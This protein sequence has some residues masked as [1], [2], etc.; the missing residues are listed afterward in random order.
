[1]KYKFLKD[2]LFEKGFYV[3]AVMDNEYP[4]FSHP[5]IPSNDFGVRVLLKENNLIGDFN[6]NVFDDIEIF[7]IT[8]NYD[9]G[10]STFDYSNNEEI[11]LIE[12]KIEQ[13]F[14]YVLELVC[15]PTAILDFSEKYYEELVKFNKTI[16]HLFNEL[17]K[18]T[19]NHK[20]GTLNQ[21]PV[22]LYPSFVHKFLYKEYNLVV[23]IHFDCL[24]FEHKITLHGQDDEI[25]LKDFTNED[26]E[27][28]INHVKRE[29]Q[30]YKF[31]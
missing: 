29:I 15:N 24:F 28:I 6:S 4:V 22:V 3:D 17:R 25:Y 10:I 23:R 13:Y 5:N 27:M 7:E 31:L 18:Q 12:D 9:L 26:I 11:I 20:V 16:K 30:F 2:T 19:L 14:Y 1:M 8:F 21:Q